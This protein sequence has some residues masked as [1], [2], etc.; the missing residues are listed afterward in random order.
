MQE[1]HIGAAGTAPFLPFKSKKTGYDL[2]VKRGGRRDRK[3][4]DKA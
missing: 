3:H 4:W 1:G 2:L